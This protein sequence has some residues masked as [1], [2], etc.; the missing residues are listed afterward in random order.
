MSYSGWYNF[1]PNG[2]AIYAAYVEKITEFVLW[3]LDHSYRVRILIGETS[4]QRAVDDILNAVR[5][6][7]PSLDQRQIVF[8]PAHSLH[9]LMGQMVHTDL[10]VATRFH[11]V[12]CA[13]KLGKPT[14]SLGYARKNDVLLADMGLGAFCQHIE[15][16]DFAQL[17]AQFSE[18]VSRRADYEKTI[19]AANVAY[20][21]RLDQQG[22]VLLTKF[23]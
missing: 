16:L 21:D 8:E 4:D 3:L 6:A 19:R 13:L 5:I 9:E 15:N 7:R 1:G 20:M 23:L 17:V 22:S 18:L 10:I 14:I 11:N 2:P 12:V